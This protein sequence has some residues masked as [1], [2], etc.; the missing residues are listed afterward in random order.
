M[1]FGCRFGAGGHARL[2]GL[3]ESGRRGV[4]PRERALEEHRDAPHE[5]HDDER[6][7]HESPDEG[8]NAAEIQLAVD[9]TAAAF[10]SAAK[11]AAQPWAC[12][13]SATARFGSF[14][15]RRDRVPSSR[16]NAASHRP[17]SATGVVRSSQWTL[18]L[19]G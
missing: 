17:K 18:S 13:S 3:G 7:G 1:G 8:E 12:T 10:G 15:G 2:P 11:S 16:A 4:L 9:R 14:A 5:A 6:D 19:P